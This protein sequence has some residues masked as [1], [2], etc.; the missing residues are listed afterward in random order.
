MNT[1]KYF[2][3]SREL[4]HMRIE[5]FQRYFSIAGDSG[6]ARAAP[7]HRATVPYY[8]SLPYTF[9]QKPAPCA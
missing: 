4:R 8:R 2:F 3:R 7:Q 6:E 5:Q 9:L 1:Q